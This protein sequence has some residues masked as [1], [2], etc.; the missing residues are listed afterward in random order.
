MS[1]DPQISPLELSIT[2]SRN[3]QKEMLATGNAESARKAGEA[4]DKALDQINDIR[5]IERYRAKD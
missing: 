5:T 4:I 1:Y 3:H 2:N